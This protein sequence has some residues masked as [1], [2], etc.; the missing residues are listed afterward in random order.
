MIDFIKSEKKIISLL[1][2]LFVFSIYLEIK[3]NEEIDKIKQGKVL[4]QKE[5]KGTS[6]EI[7][8]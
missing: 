6:K 2:V 3:V 5:V 1:G 8:N 7:N 4:A